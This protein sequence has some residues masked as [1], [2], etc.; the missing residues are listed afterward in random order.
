MPGH[1]STSPAGSL[2]QALQVP[3]ISGKASSRSRFSC[4]RAPT[5]VMQP[6]RSVTVAIMSARLNIPCF[7]RYGI[8][9]DDAQRRPAAVTFYPIMPR[10]EAHSIDASA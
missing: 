6:I 3:R 4:A 7:S 10:M 8:A 5:A 1:S 2:W 9:S